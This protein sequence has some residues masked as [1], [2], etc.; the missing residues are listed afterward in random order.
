MNSQQ[1]KNSGLQVKAFDSLTVEIIPSDQYEFVMSNKEVAH[2]YG[3]ADSTLRAQISRHKDEFE[4][5]KHFFLGVAKCNA[6]G[7]LPVRTKM[8]TK[9]GIIR[10]GMFIKSDRAKRFRDWAES[11]IL[12]RLDQKPNKLS[13][14]K[15]GYPRKRN[16]N[17][18]TPSRLLD[19]M[20]EVVKIED[21]QVRKSIA[22]KLLGKGD[23]A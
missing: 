16:D 4:D 9:A 11:L 8:W 17:R 22:N 2:A 5:G 19:I 18:L 7:N 20:T 13:K 21:S 14:L 23:D 10:L 12:E 6:R 3:V 15:K 1:A